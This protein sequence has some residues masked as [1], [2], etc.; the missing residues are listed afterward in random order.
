MLPNEQEE[1]K[2]RIRDEIDL[3]SVQVVQ[4]LVSTI[5]SSAFTVNY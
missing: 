5:F 1:S 3:Q 4:V 2:A